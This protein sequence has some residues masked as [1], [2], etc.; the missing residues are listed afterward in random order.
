MSAGWLASRR[1]HASAGW[2]ANAATLGSSDD[3]VAGT[4]WCLQVR[5]SSA[6]AA[7]RAGR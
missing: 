2:R 7:G 1:R 3:E 6:E 4:G 5:F